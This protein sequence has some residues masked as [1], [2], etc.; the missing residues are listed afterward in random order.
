[1]WPSKQFKMFW[2]AVF[3]YAY[4]EKIPIFRFMDDDIN[5]QLYEYFDKVKKY[6]DESKAKYLNK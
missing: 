6:I 5:R 1:M 2:S 3:D 4:D